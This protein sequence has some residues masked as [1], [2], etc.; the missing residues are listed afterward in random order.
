[1][2]D[3][4][5]RIADLPTSRRQLFERLLK[6]KIGAP[7]LQ[8]VAPKAELMFDTGSSSADDTKA[9]YR[10]FYNGVSE[11]LNNSDFGDFSFFL[12]Y[13]YV[14]D[15]NPQYAQV[16][17]PAHYLNKNSVRLALELID[18]CEITGRRVLDVGCGRGGT[19][20][21]IQKFFAPQS[22]T[23]VD[24]SSVAISFCH[25]THRHSQ[26]RFMEAD[27]EALPF[28]ERAFDVVTNVE[29]S[30]SYPHI[31]TFY[32]EVSR[33]L[34]PGGYF[35][36]TDVLPIARMNECEKLL[37]RAGF[38]VE[39]LRDITTNVVLSCDQIAETRTGAFAQA[40]NP[41][42]LDEFLALPGSDVY[43]EMRQRQCV[44][45]MFKLKKTEVEGDG[46]R[47]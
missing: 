27:A 36:Y 3:L 45:H 2:P 35:L 14:A 12:N 17:L 31:E 40:Q 5:K 41:G 19:I 1:M 18:D 44:Y 9:G 15:R 39:R 10:R 16:Q 22:I 38:S 4:A 26:I 7:K 37:Q 47:G 6:E 33:V 8:P 34:V 24:I 20:S 25:K 42:T 46:Q 13:G 43:E 11:Q 30:H 32:T 23:G 28:R 29:S 21:V